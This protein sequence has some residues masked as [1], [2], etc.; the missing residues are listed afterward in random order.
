MN[1]KIVSF[2]FLLFGPTI[3]NLESKIPNGWGFSSSLSLALCG[4]Q[5]RRSSQEKSSA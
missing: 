4:A 2:D 1:I 5:A 3:G